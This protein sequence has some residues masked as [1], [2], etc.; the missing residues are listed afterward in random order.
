MIRDYNNAATAAATKTS[1]NKFLHSEKTGEKE[2]RMVRT[3]PVIYIDDLKYEH[4]VKNMGSHFSCARIK[5]IDLIHNQWRGNKIKNSTFY[6]E[7]IFDKGFK[8][9]KDSAR[10]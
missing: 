4:F 1:F 8:Y 5:K 3:W 10:N 6:Y 9:H 2:I 7:T